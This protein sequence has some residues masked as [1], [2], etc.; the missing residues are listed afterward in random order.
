[1]MKIQ[2]WMPYAPLIGLAIGVA[3]A[4]EPKKADFIPLSTPLETN[5]KVE[6]WSGRGDLDLLRQRFMD[7]S[8]KLDARVAELKKAHK[9][10]GCE[11]N[12]KLE[13]DCA[14]REKK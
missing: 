2:T 7:E 13:W 11:L 10:E 8:Q 4:Q 9:A 1:M 12:P 3:I 14:K 6:I 5:E